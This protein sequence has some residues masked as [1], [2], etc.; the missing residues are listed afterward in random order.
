MKK[1]Y[2][3]FCVMIPFASRLYVQKA[4]KVRLM[5]MKICTSYSSWNDDMLL[6]MFCSRN[7]KYYES[8][9]RLELLQ[10]MEIREARKQGRRPLQVRTFKPGPEEAGL[11]GYYSAGAECLYLNENY[12]LDSRSYLYDYSVAAALSTLLHEGRHAYQYEVATGTCPAPDEETMLRWR[13]N[14]VGYLGGGDSRESQIMYV[15]QSLERDARAYAMNELEN[16]YRRM[17]RNVGCDDFVYQETLND[18]RRRENAYDELARTI[19]T[20]QLMDEVDRRIREAYERAFPGVKAPNV[21]V[22]DEWRRQLDRI[23]EVQEREVRKY[24]EYDPALNDATRKIAER[25]DAGMVGE[26][27]DRSRFVDRRAFACVL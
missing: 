23:R 5:N 26:Y 22:F 3:E 13:L 6:E 9:N 16:L 11:M 12:V 14:Y 19:L 8:E 4:E 17:S 20:R 7:W 24:Q 25:V 10:E 18:M 2:L 1:K 27:T 15:Q 21:S